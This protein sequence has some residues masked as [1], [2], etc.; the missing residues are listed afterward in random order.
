MTKVPMIQVIGRAVPEWIADH[1][2]QAVPKRVQLRI[3]DR[4]HGR[5][6]LTGRKIGAADKWDLDHVVSLTRGGQHRESNLKPALRDKHREKTASEN[7]EDARADRRKAF[8]L[9]LKP[10][11]KGNNRIPSRPFSRRA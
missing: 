9:G 1:P 2:D 4:E 8:H 10:K 5:C 3:W 6:H 7:S 11:P